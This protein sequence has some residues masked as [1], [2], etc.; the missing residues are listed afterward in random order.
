MLPKLQVQQSL[1]SEMMGVDCETRSA[2]DAHC[3][4]DNR[5]DDV[6]EV[7]HLENGVDEMHVE[8]DG[9]APLSS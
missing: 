7:G 4:A 1:D 2:L 6:S 3:D 5:I 9:A 8:G